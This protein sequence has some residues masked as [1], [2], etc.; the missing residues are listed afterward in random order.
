MFNKHDRTFVAVLLLV[1]LGVSATTHSTQTMPARSEKQNYADKNP[2]HPFSRS[3][4]DDNEIDLDVRGKHPGDFSARCR[5]T[6]GA[7]R[8]SVDVGCLP[9]RSALRL[10]S[11]RF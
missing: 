7:Y 3:V 8:N 11:M 5:K 2:D 6:M 1:W 10:G 9:A 4:M